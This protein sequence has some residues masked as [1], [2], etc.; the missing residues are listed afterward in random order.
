MKPPLIDKWRP[1]LTFVLGGGLL[2]TLILSFV[3]LVALRYLGP[4]IGFR[5]A[6]SLLATLILMATAILGWLLVRLLLSPIR[7]LQDYAASMRQNP[8]EVSKAPEHSGTKELHH[9]AQSVV[10]MAN[11]LRNREV[12]IRSFT[13]HVSHEIKTPV[14]AI[15]AAAELIQDS[16]ALGPEDQLLVRQILGATQQI[17]EQLTALREVARAREIR[18]QGISSLVSHLNGLK[19][20]FS[21]LKLHFSGEAL[22][23]PLSDEGL[24]ILLTHLLRNA[25]EHGA[26]AV[27]V[28]A[29]SKG[30]TLDLLVA[31]NGT[32]ISPGNAANIFDPFFTTKRDQGGTGMGLAILRNMLGVHGAKI[33]HLPSDRGAR[34][35]I[36]FGQ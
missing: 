9:M 21:D 23:I 33:S 31:D 25:R 36:R 34:F 1:S 26:D 18:H 29:S 22:H 10:E 3:G 30:P 32:G 2:G 15:R 35:L 17:E 11:H 4:E 19:E 14:S 13:D 7:S 16:G 27:S 24:S 20:E 8:Q 5:N 6:A 12:T 28:T